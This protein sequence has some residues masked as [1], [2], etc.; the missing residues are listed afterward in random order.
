[1]GLGPEDACGCIP[2]AGMLRAARMHGLECTRLDL[3]NSGDTTGPA[4]AGGAREGVG[5]GAWAFMASGAGA[6]LAARAF[7]LSRRL[8]LPNSPPHAILPGNATVLRPSTFRR[9]TTRFRGKSV[10]WPVHP[11]ER[12]FRAARRCVLGGAEAGVARLV[13]C[14]EEALPVER[15]F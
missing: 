10:A 15:A 2:I 6:A 13:N 4:G 3:R 12:V 11:G 14:G 9:E 5:Y 7:R 1:R 8:G